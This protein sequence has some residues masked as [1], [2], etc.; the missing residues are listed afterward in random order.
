MVLLIHPSVGGR[1]PG[2]PVVQRCGLGAFQCGSLRAG[3]SDALEDPKSTP[4]VARQAPTYIA[5]VGLRRCVGEPARRAGTLRNSGRIP[6]GVANEGGVTLSAG[7]VVGVA[8]RG[9]S[10]GTVVQQ[11]L[12]G[13]GGRVVWRWLRSRNISPR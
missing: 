5:S 1:L 6:G 11:W 10:A 8:G 13:Q 12:E 9:N 3:W 4:P 2:G 7:R